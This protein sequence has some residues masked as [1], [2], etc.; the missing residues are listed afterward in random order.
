MCAKT[1]AL[2]A[3]GLSITAVAGKLRLSRETLYDWERQKP[4]F[5]DAIKRGRSARVAYLEEQLLRGNWRFI[6]AHIFALKNAA[7]EEWRD[8]TEQAHTV[9]ASPVPMDVLEEARKILRE[10]K[11]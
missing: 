8:K 11:R 9:T 2:M 10:V 5:S 4:E 6:T 1:V 7:P 3:S